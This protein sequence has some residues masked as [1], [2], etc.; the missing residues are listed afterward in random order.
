MCPSKRVLCFG[1]FGRVCAGLAPRSPPLL[2]VGG[3][4]RARGWGVLFVAAGL[5]VVVVETWG[6]SPH[7]PFEAVQGCPPVG[8]DAR[9]YMGF[10]CCRR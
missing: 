6:L 5:R 4:R 9:Q 1:W 3:R 8:I 2:L 7:A 10:F